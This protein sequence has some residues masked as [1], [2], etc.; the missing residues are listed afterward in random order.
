MTRRSLLARL[1]FATRR[2]WRLAL[3]T[4]LL[5]VLALRALTAAAAASS[6][7]GAATAP[8]VAAVAT[9][10]LELSG[11]LRTFEAALPAMRRWLFPALGGARSMSPRARLGE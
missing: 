2:H 4:A 11:E 9:V 6:S 5:A 3:A 7:R 10:A 1:A 8:A